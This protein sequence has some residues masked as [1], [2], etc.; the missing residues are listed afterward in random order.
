M[1][2]TWSQSAWYVRTGLLV[3]PLLCGAAVVHVVGSP[4]GT[5]AVPA[6][7]AW[8]TPAG[9]RAASPGAPSA[10]GAPDAPMAAPVLANPQMTPRRVWVNT[11]GFWSWALL[12]RRT[13]KIVG[14]RNPTATSTTASMIKVWLAADFLRRAAESGTTPDS[15]QL[16]RLSTMIRDSA[17]D[18][19][20][21]M[22]ALLGGAASTRRLIGVCG[23]TDSAPD[24]RWSNTVVSARDTA[25]LA[26]CIAD[27][28][29]AGP[30]WTPWLLTE[31]L[32]VRG[33]GD[34]GIRD[35]LPP[36]SA[37]GVA[38]KNGWVV[39]MQGTEWHVACLAV[40]AGWT[41]GVLARYPQE[42][43]LT[44]G[45]QICERVAAALLRR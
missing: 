7:P 3:I 13:N 23:L 1:V 28:R 36:A 24:E 35:A 38:I 20:Q 32:G 40:A 9:T 15:A 37:A 43:G 12:D 19:A 21:E 30:Q 2:R 8:V 39:R 45:A 5:K 22:F 27:A 26:D 44:H 6:A 33:L 10:S 4:G 16:Q 18:P 25:R 29:A 42:L 11:P 14:S 41:L 17:N 31:M 34:F